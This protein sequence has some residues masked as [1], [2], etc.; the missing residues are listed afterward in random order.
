MQLRKHGPE[1]QHAMLHAQQQTP[2]TFKTPPPTLSA[3]DIEDRRR[4]LRLR[5]STLVD[6]KMDGIDRPGIKI[7]ETLDEYRQAFGLA[8]EAYVKSGY[9]PPDPGHP[10]YYSP[11]SFLPDTCLFVFKSYLTVIASLTEIFD[12]PALG[13]PMDD[14]YKEELDSLRSNN[15]SIVELSSF[16]TSHEY[17]MRNIMVFLSRVMLDYSLMNNVNDIC[18]MVNPKHVRFYTLMFLFEPFGKE[19][20]YSKVQAPA[21]ALRLNMD[22]IEG[23]LRDKYS[24]F[25]F[26]EDLYSFFYRT[27]TTLNMLQSGAQSCKKRQLSDEIL[28]FFHVQA[29]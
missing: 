24:K 7:A 3:A 19:K 13:L 9:I 27:N 18:I 11:Y 22:D 2:M 15:R 23:R 29:T 10:Y 25:N 20:F 26:T 12:S 17:R 16:V 1:L 6:L 5:K 21:V 4:T 14:L 28:R 8:Y